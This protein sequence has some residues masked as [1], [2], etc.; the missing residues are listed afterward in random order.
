MLISFYYCKAEMNCLVE[1]TAEGKK[2]ER[3]SSLVFNGYTSF[4]VR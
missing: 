4:D 3:L 1:V 2:I